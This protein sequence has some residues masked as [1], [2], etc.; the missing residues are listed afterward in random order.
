MLP[1]MN[2]FVKQSSLK[3]REA[4]EGRGSQ[5]RPRRVEGAKGGIDFVNCSELHNKVPFDRALP[6]CH[7]TSSYFSTY[8]A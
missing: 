6:F 5:R 3:L 7:F 2:Q 8:L 4:K 1:E